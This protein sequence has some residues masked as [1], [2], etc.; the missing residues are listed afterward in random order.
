MENQ[1][2]VTLERELSELSAQIVALK[3]ALEVKPDY[4]MGVGDPAVTSWEL[5]R[6]LLQR[7]ETR[8][9]ELRAAMQ[10]LEQGTYG[11]CER[12]GQP[13]HPDRLAALPGTRLCIAC[14]S[15]G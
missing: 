8:E 7:L 14:A 5:N 4:G 13:I 6:A 15:R 9:S 10:R 3:E 1:D 11:L 2:R 12:C